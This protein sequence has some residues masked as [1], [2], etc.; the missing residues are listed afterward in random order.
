MV[1]SYRFEKTQ[2]LNQ[3]SFPIH[4]QKEKNKKIKKEKT[5][6]KKII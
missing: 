5:N 2:Q 1:S 4:S 3:K 6:G